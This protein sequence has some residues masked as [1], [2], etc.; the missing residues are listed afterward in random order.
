MTNADGDL[1]RFREIAV[2][3]GGGLLPDGT[4]NEYTLARADAAAELAKVRDIALIVAGSH[5]HGRRPLVTEAELMARRLAALGVSPERI[6]LED[7]SRDTLSNAAFVAERYLSGI[8]PRPLFIVT[9]PFHM[10]RSLATF[11]LVLGPT[12]RLHAYAAAR[13]T[14]EDAHAVTEELYL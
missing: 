11:G 12:W 9:S 2:V 6:F 13:G 4:P 8:A 1:S 10:A 5:G 7:R 3:L 14:Q